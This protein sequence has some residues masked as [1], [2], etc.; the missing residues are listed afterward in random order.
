LHVDSRQADQIERCCKN[1]VAPP[2]S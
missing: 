2:Q 1:D